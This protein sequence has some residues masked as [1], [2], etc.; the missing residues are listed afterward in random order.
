M[1]NKIFKFLTLTVILVILLPSCSNTTNTLENAPEVTEL[2]RVTRNDDGVKINGGKTIDEAMDYYINKI[3][4]SLGS[5]GDFFTGK[6]RIIDTVET[7]ENVN[8]YSWIVSQWVDKSGN[9]ESAHS[10]LAKVGFKKENN[11]YIYENHEY[12]DYF[13]NYNHPYIPQKV[14]DIL[15]DNI[16]TIYNE[17]KTEVDKEVEN[18]VNS[19]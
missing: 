18:Y 19:Q 15:K 2:P 12:Y 9:I 3:E 7:S 6:Y 16:D 13:E 4:S 1:N 17:L 8:V 5:A 10:R 11:L 14:N